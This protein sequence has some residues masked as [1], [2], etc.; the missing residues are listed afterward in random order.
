MIS[1][2]PQETE[3]LAARLAERLEPGDVV[4]VSGELGS[5]KTTFVRGAAHALGVGEPVTSPTFTIA[6]RYAGRVQVSHLDLYRF[7]ILT[8]ADWGALEPYFEE[9]VV[10]C[11]WPEAAAGW[12]PR[13]RVAVRLEHA[14]GDRRRIELESDEA[15]LLA[16]LT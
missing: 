3:R 12:L 11:E 15:E 13:S 1:S 6:H 5:G 16:G 2:S 8:E 9:A 10:F 14:D 7:E 4:T